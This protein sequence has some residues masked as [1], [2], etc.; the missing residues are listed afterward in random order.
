M[1]EKE[2]WASEVKYLFSK[3]TG[4]RWNNQNPTLIEHVR[5]LQTVVT[6]DQ[7]TDTKKKHKLIII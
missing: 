2:Q 3:L 7:I 4:N 5:S 1:R 6:E